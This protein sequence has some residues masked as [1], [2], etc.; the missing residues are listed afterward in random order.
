M[1]PQDAPRDLSGADG[2]PDPLGAPG[3]PHCAGVSQGRRQGATAA[4]AA[5]DAARALRSAVLQPE[6][7]GD[8]GPACEAE[9]IRRFAGAVL[10]KGTIVDATIISAPPPRDLERN[11]QR[12]ALLL[13]FS[14]LMIAQPHL[15]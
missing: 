14:N 13:G 2:R 5:R 3:G 9:S 15:S 11:V 12:L 8:G 4:S 7:P 10:K 6:R 1:R